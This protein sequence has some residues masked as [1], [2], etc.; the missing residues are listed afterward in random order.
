VVTTPDETA[1]VDSSNPSATITFP[2]AG[3]AYNTTAWGGGACANAVCGTASDNHAVLGIAVT[4]QRTA[5]AQYWN[6]TTWQSGLFTHALGGTS[7]SLPLPAEALVDGAYTVTARASDDAGNTATDTNAFTFDDTT[8][9]LE[10]LDML[11]KDRD[12]KVDRVLAT[13]SENVV[14][15][16]SASHWTLA[17]I[18]SNG[19]RGSLSFD[20][21]EVTLGIS[22]GSG[23]V[24]TAV[25][26]FTVALAANSSTG[27][28]DAAGNA[29][30]FAAMAPTDKARPLIV[31][32]ADQAGAVNGT[33]QGKAEAGDTFDV[34]FSEAV[35]APSSPAS[36]TLSRAGTGQPAR[37][38]VPEV[39]SVLSLGSSSYFA[40]SFGSRTGTFSNSQIN[41]V[42]DD[43]TIRVTL[44]AYSGDTLGTSGGGAIDFT[45]S[46]AVRDLGDNQV[47]GTFTKSGSNPVF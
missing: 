2:V 27:I 35:Q 7:W 37:L 6:G 9:T 15:S 28:R 33:A 21:S 44:G 23:A 24:D 31:S 29:A 11:E 12:G 26:S 43:K 34:T 4:V 5:D 3:V 1:V 18:P 45:P 16:G 25:G 17:N 40:S 22:E 32:I 13:F 36:V 8:P 14:A 46:S 42:N 41:R 10:S 30:S 47:T 38:T 19:A 20:G 39:T